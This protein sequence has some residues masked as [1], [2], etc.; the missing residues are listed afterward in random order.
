M[1]DDQFVT[2]V[3]DRLAGL[4][5]VHAVALGGSRARGTHTPDSDWDFAVYYRGSFQPSDLR[6]LGWEGEV[7]EL[8]AWGGIFNSGAWLTIDG[9]HVDVHYRDLDAI[10]HELAEAGHGRFRWE[11]LAFHLA[12][13]PSYLLLAELAGARVLHGSLPRPADPDAL[14][15]AAAQQWRQQA[16]LT[17]RYA[18]DAFVRRGQATEL[19]GALATAAMQM[20]H[21]VLARRGE[22]V[23]NEKRLLARAGLRDVDAVIAGL[24]PEPEALEQAL[25]E[26]R[27][28]LDAAG[29]RGPAGRS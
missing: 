5:A 10:E 27:T 21:A 14:R 2:H 7:F 13:I 25:A 17:L 26:A 8:G 12:G 4:P 18:Q 15:T 11:P 22:W 28:L 20:A 6:A 19:A 16:S 3:A 9:R 1:N 23:T 24:R 29:Q